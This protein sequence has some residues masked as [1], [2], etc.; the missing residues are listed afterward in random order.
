[1]LCN[2]SGIYE[3]GGADRGWLYDSCDE[4]EDQHVLQTGNPCDDSDAAEIPLFIIVRDLCACFEDTG[5]A[6]TLFSLR[7]FYTNSP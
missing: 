6:H 1:M 4:P 2:G 7:T 5:Q 3:Y